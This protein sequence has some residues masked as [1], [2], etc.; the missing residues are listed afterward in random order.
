MIL[1]MN[2][3][4]PFELLLIFLVALLVFGAKRLPEIGRS[5]G[6]TIREFKRAINLSWDETEED[7]KRSEI[8]AP[9]K[10]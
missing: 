3:P 8:P 10:N 1:P 5:L 7:K 4:G 9:P 2:L 6:T